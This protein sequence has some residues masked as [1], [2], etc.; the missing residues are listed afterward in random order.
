MVLAEL[1][2]DVTLWC[3]EHPEVTIATFLLRL[4]EDTRRVGAQVRL[5]EGVLSHR[6]NQ[7]LHQRGQ[8][9]VPSADR[10]ACQG[11]PLAS[12]DA[13]QPIERQMVL[14]ATDDCIR[15]H[16]RASEATS[17]RQRWSCPD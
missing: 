15:Q 2:Q 10:R 14:P 16:A 8:L 13:F 6:R 17:D 9:I 3:N 1:E 4:D 5:L 7:W 11:H 12:V